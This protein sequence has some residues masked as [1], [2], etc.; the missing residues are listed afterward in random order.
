MPTSGQAARQPIRIL[1]V[2]AY[3]PPYD[4][5]RPPDWWLPGTVQPLLE[6]PPLT[7]PTTT[8]VG[9]SGPDRP[10]R[11]GRVDATDRP[12][13]VASTQTTAAAARFVNTCLEILNGYRPV[14]HF[15]AL[16]D[17]LAAATVLDAMAHAVDRLRPMARRDGLV[18]LRVMR[19]CE[20][21]PGVAE[22]ALVVGIR[23]DPGAGAGGRVGR[24]RVG[25]A[26]GLAF[27]LE[28]RLGRWLCT[29]ARML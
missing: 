23:G 18:K 17:P 19:T 25:Q 26:W 12:G 2:P 27:R 10:L 3:D 5:E 1:P 11:A 24:D 15:R 21:R 28:R 14:A 13:T 8:A 29:A 7:G 16:S 6:L 9:A 22:I 4:D 20:P